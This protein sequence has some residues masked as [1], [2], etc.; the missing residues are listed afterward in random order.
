MACFDQRTQ[1]RHPCCLQGVRDGD[2][3][4]GGELVEARHYRFLKIAEGMIRFARILPVL[5]RCGHDCS[6]ES[7]RVHDVWLGDYSSSVCALATPAPPSKRENIP[8]F[9]RLGET[10]C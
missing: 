4:F 9:F 5:L 10:N 6:G 3:L 2:E 8:I 1:S 7:S